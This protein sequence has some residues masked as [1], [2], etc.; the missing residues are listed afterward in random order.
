MLFLW[1][2]LQRLQSQRIQFCRCRCGALDSLPNRPA[3]A[4]ILTSLI[5]MDTKNVRCSAIK[6]L[7]IAHA[8]P[9]YSSFT[10]YPAKEIFTY[11]LSTIRHWTI[12]ST[13]SKTSSIVS[14]CMSSHFLT[15]K[16]MSF[17][18]YTGNISLNRNWGPGRVVSMS[19]S[20]LAVS[21]LVIVQSR[22][23]VMAAN[24]THW[25]PCQ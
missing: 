6:C 16:P 7:H 20:S 13:A 22:T 23:E 1:L 19:T 11:S 24:P 17:I 18:K 25:C 14:F 8:Y 3:L 21:L 4:K 12:S 9:A 2:I 5:S 10:L 15:L